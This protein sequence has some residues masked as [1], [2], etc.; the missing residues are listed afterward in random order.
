[1]HDVWFIQQGVRPIEG[2]T[3]VDCIAADTIYLNMY[4]HI[5]V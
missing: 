5:Y 1:M 3:H 2:S 4:L